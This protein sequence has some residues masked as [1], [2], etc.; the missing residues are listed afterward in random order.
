MEF[1]RSRRADEHYASQTDRIRRTLRDSDMPIVA[2]TESMRPA[3]EVFGGLTEVDDKIVGVRVVYPSPLPDGPWVSVHTARWTGTRTRSGPL[4]RLVEHRLRQQGERLSLFD[5]SE[6][7]ATV[8]VDGEPVN[9]RLVRAGTRWW[10]ARCNRADVEISVLAENWHPDTI[11][12]D[13]V[14]DVAPM[15][16]RLRSHP[17]PS[18]HRS[19]EPLPEPLRGEPHRALVDIVLRS[20]QQQSSWMAD[21]GPV[22]ELP[23]YWSTLWTA[24]IQRQIALTDQSEPEARDS[25]R[26]LA[27]HMSN[28]HHDAAWFRD[29]TDLRTRAIAET[30]L[31]CTMPDASVPSR[32]AQQAWRHRQVVAGT[33]HG[34]EAAAAADRA[35]REAWIT[36][37]N[38]VG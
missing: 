2:L 23:A 13:T 21:G 30:L 31:H 7:P 32:P 9:G 35:W 26:G 15:L 22:P 27:D 1:D 25:V 28:L 33:H 5:W 17:T 38:T 11:A 14:A 29:N 8:L 12:V 18:R 34:P 36:W 16:E 20:A 4:R 10:A 6:E 19:P 37:I 3:D 24:A